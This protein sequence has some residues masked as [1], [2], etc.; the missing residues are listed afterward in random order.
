MRTMIQKVC[1]YVKK[2]SQHERSILWYC[3]WLDDIGGLRSNFLFQVLSMSRASG[4]R[5][6]AGSSYDKVR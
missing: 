6:R 3:E 5:L 4:V 2:G 1:I